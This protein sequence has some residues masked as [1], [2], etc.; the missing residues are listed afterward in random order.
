VRDKA[1]DDLWNFIDQG[2]PL[3]EQLAAAGGDAGAVGDEAIKLLATEAGKGAAALYLLRDR[4]A[5]AASTSSA[6]A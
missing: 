5:A 6:A 3:L 2:L 1:L 4:L